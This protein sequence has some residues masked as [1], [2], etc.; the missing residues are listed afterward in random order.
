MQWVA[1]KHFAFAVV[2]L[3][4]IGGIF[5]FFSTSSISLEPST[6][7]VQY[8]FEESSITIRVTTEASCPTR[9]I[10]LGS[11]RLSE[12]ATVAG[13]VDFVHPLLL[14][15]FNAAKMAA[16]ADGVNLYIT[17]GY[18]S[19]ERQGELFA[20]AVVKYGSESEAAKWVLPPQFS[21][22]PEG[23][24]LDINYPGDRAG[25][26]W[27]EANGSRFGLCRVYAN[28]WWHFEGVS[29]PG[30]PC[31]AMAANALVDLG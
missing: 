31:P 12:S 28:E 29:A 4:I 3:P 22:H 20:E 14:N 27:L 13:R 10:P 1:S 25:A 30:E 11:G 7:V 21:H 2:V 19:R 6:P 8:C 15:R 24:A 9:L 26:Q 23:L 18:R 16:D 5:T 17:S